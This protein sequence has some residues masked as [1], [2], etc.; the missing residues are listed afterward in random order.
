MMARTVMG[1]INALTS[2]GFQSSLPKI[3]DLLKHLIPILDGRS[4]AASILEEGGGR[5]VY[6]PHEPL[7]DRFVVTNT[8]IHV[9]GLKTNIIKVLISISNLRAQFRLGNLLKTFRD[10]TQNPKLK[11]ELKQHHRLFTQNKTYMFGPEKELVSKLFKD[12]EALFEEGDGLE[13]QLEKLGKESNLKN[14]S[15]VGSHI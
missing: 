9:T 15:C 7:T 3:K 12:F 6:L 8:S 1:L 13:L 4:D 5:K 11:V 2:F 14:N 10:Y